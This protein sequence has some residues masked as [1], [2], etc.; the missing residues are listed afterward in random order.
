[1]MYFERIEKRLEIAT[2]FINA[3]KAQATKNN[4]TELIKQIDSCLQQIKNI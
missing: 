1:M 3:L 2:D 4:Q